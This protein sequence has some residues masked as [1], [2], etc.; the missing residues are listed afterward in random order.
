MTCEFWYL[1]VYLCYNNWS[2]IA[3]W[4]S[5]TAVLNNRSHCTACSSTKCLIFLFS[6]RSWQESLQSLAATKITK[7]DWGMDI[8]RDQAARTALEELREASD[9]NW[10]GKPIVRF[11]GEKADDGGGPRRE[12]FTLLF[13]HQGLFEGEFFRMTSENRDSN[14]YTVLGKAVAFSL[15]FGHPGPQRLHPSLAKYILDD[16]EPQDDE[17]EVTDASTLAV[18]KQVSSHLMTT[19]VNKLIRQ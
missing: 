1:H 8:I 17:I 14:S 3:C 6:S 16:T 2:S 15:L 9:D 7:P 19:I 11:I 12:M 18:I 10:H 5:I 13:S 4:V